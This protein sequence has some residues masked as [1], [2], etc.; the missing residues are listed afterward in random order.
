[1]KFKV[2]LDDE[3]YIRFNIYNA[4]HSKMGRKMILRGRLLGLA[5]SLLVLF[6]M[7]MAGAERSL[8]LVETA[9]LAVFSAVCWFMYPRWAEKSIRK[10]I[11]KM[12]E[13]GPLP[14][15]KETVLEFRESDIF[16]ERLNGTRTVRYTEITGVEENDAYIYL[17]KSAQE[18]ILVPEK[19]LT[20]PVAD[21]LAFI[22]EKT[23]AR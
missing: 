6:V 20:V 11:M 4:F 22:K 18:A 19:Y 8:I 16:E 23:G 9:F 1:M 15:E 10:Q 7:F 2:K 3:D 13:E 14:Y 12:K 5:I 21:F 17:R